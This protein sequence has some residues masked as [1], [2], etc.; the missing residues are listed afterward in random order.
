M[1]MKGRFMMDY[2]EYLDK[3]VKEAQA[4]VTVV[5]DATKETADKA[6]NKIDMKKLELDPM[7]R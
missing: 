7:Y 3:L 6:K 4:L 5:T 1:G 2:R